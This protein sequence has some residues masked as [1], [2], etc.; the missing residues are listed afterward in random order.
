MFVKTT[1]G[2][3]MSQVYQIHFLKS[4]VRVD[5]LLLN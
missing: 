1:E 5:M 3:G 2:I 4:V